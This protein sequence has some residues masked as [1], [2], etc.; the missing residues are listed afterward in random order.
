[1]NSQE[2]GNEVQNELNK[3]TQTHGKD[4]IEFSIAKQ[5]STLTPVAKTIIWFN[6]NPN[7]IKK[8]YDGCCVR[9]EL[10]HNE[11]LTG[12]YIYIKLQF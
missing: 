12:Q 1:M 4:K 7:D 10:T 6:L 8:I 2:I 5:V 3:L 11:K 9:F